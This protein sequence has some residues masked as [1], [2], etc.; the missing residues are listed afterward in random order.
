M[1]STRRAG[2]E[3]AALVAVLTRRARGSTFTVVVV[4]ALARKVIV[5]VPRASSLVAV[6]Y[7]TA[8]RVELTEEV[9]MPLTVAR[10]GGEM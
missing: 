4:G 8:A 10:V 5:I 3:L 7:A 9:T 6:M 1:G 2:R